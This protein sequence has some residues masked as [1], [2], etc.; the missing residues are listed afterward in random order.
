MERDFK[1]EEYSTNIPTVCENPIEDYH[2]LYVN[3]GHKIVKHYHSDLL[4]D[5]STISRVS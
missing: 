2:A 1:Y 4:I 3:E 5:C